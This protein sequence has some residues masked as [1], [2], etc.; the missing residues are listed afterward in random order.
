VGAS[1]VMELALVG[2]AL[3]VLALVGVALV[4]GWGQACRRCTDWPAPGAHSSNI[5]VAPIFV[6]CVVSKPRFLPCQG[7]RLPS[8]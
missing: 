7:Y 1:V 2:L 6:N 5:S 8:A 3:V 4:D